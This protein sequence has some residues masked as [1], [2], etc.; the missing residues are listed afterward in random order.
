MQ[1]IDFH[2]V[3]RR[4]PVIST[5]LWLSQAY[6]T[7]CFKLSET[8][9]IESLLFSSNGHLLNVWDKNSHIVWQKVNRS[10]KES[11]KLRDLLF[12]FLEKINFVHH[13]LFKR[14][15]GE[16]NQGQITLN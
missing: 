13:S 14:K 5:S 9:T 8:S 4:M 7:V 11:N 12:I 6:P 15:T 16:N 10:F 1:N 3:C 2:L